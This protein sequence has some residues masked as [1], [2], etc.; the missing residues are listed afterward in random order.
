[1]TAK[2]ASLVSEQQLPQTPDAELEATQTRDK[3]SS[4]TKSL[5]DGSTNMGFTAM[6]LAAHQVPEMSNSCRSAS[7]ASSDQGRVDEQSLNANL[8]S[9]PAVPE[10]VPTPH[11]VPRAIY[12]LPSEPSPA[13]TRRTTSIDSTPK[14]LRQS[15]PALTPGSGS[16]REAATKTT[17][18]T[19]TKQAS[20]HAPASVGL[21]ARSSSAGPSCNETKEPAAVE[22][23]VAP[24]PRLCSTPRLRTPAVFTSQ[25]PQSA[26]PQSA[27]KA[28]PVVR[29]A[30]DKVESY[31][32]LF[33]VPLAF[34][35]RLLT[36]TLL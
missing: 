2:D 23:S 5:P 20:P 13:I 22:D 32:E 28:P 12:N 8:E 11:A 7:I 10:F 27:R 1:M 29:S 16:N 35:L 17:G 19:D 26:R 18:A 31:M 3:E 9:S 21:Y 4:S 30:L 24:T 14:S 15:R 25:R 33:Y 6:E 36:C 34:L